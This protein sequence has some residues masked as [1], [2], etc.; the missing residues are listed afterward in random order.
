MLDIRHRQDRWR[1]LSGD[2]E[3]V[4][5]NICY[6]APKA[7]KPDPNIGAAAASSAQTAADALA[8]N[9]MIY[10]QDAPKR[11]QEYDLAKRFSDSAIAS[12][13]FNDDL[14][15]QYFD[16][17]KSVFYP[18]ENSMADQAAVAGG[19]DDQEMYA[20]QARGS[21][22]T[23][24][25]NQNEQNARIAQSFGINPNSGR[26]LGMLQQQGVSNAAIEA[27]AM[28]QARIAARNLGWAKQSDVA[29]M[30]RNLPS[31]Q[32]TSSQVALQ[33]TGTGLGAVHQPITSSL[34]YQSGMNQGYGVGLQGYNNQG[35]LGLGIYNGQLNAYSQK[36]GMY[37]TLVGAGATLGAAGIGGM[38]G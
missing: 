22:A 29:N 24:Q 30:G 25:A 15:K 38:M 9:K 33:S 37:G 4:N 34:G 18:I 21:N 14:S 20:N 19:A 23:S 7:P 11:Q 32:A 5:P 8:W 36:L 6:C 17:M 31:S 10:E 3:F 1:R 27:N 26:Y 12:Q 35:N 13:Q 2:I 28:T 16:R